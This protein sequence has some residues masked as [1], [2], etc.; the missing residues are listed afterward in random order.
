MYYDALQ[1]LPATNVFLFLFYITLAVF[2][3]VNIVTGVFVET[4]MQANNRDREVLVNEEMDAKR[5]YLLAMRDVFEEMDTGLTGMVSVDEFERCL[6]QER[7]FAYF[8]TMKLTISDARQMFDLIDSDESG[9]VS[10]DEFLSGCYRLQGES[11]A[12]DVKVM[13][14]EIKLLISAFRDFGDEQR[15]MADTLASLTS[16]QRADGSGKVVEP[17]P[18]QKQPASPSSCEIVY[19]QHENQDVCL[20]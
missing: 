20:E 6:N 1:V 14:C 3:V 17:L 11:R 18:E 8:Q 15:Q 10:I 9:E 5:S 12:L 19:F 2:A 4:A 7:V 13:Q 16:I